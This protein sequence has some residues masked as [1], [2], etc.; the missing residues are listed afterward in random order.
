MVLSR[1]AM[2]LFSEL[3]MFML[4][5]YN[6]QGK[7]GLFYLFKSLQNFHTYM[8]ALKLKMLESAFTSGTQVGVIRQILS[9]SD[10]KAEEPINFFALLSGAASIGSIAASNPAYSG[11]LSAL[12]GVFGLLNEAVPRP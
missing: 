12:S 11:G 7:G 8:A 4:G 3:T 1:L 6:A 9:L 2:Y 10:G 5:A